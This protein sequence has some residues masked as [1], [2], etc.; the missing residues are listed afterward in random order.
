MTAINYQPDLIEYIRPL[1]SISTSHTTPT[2]HAYFNH[3]NPGIFPPQNDVRAPGDGYIVK[4]GTMAEHLRPAPPGQPGTVEDYRV[5]I[6]HSCTFLTIFIHL[7]GLAPEIQEVTGELGQGS[8]WVPSESSPPIPVKAGQVIGKV[9]IGSFDFGV[10]DAEVTL[11]GFVI[12]SRYDGEPWK[13]HTVDPFGPFEEPLRTQL[14]EKSLRTAEPRGGRID[15]DIDGRLV[16][17]WFPA[18]TEYKDEQTALSFVYNYLNPTQVRIS[19]GGLV[20]HRGW[21]VR[22]NAPD[23][24]DVT[25]A[26][27]LIKYEITRTGLGGVNEETRGSLLV[28]MLGERRIKMEVFLEQ[29]PDQVQGFTSAAR[30]YER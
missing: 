22:G 1:G 16:G 24:A 7:N 9:G 11:S 6:S 17:N 3:R 20:E 15:F 8:R 26:S 29:A 14:R 19:V 10:Y 25:P 27:G 18:G 21:G 23:P 12:P 13:I 2:D 4:I 5:I 28:Q 30:I